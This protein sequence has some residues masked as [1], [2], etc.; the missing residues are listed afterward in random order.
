[1]G[2]A[3]QADEEGKYVKEEVLHNLI[4]RMRATSDDV[5]HKAS[6]LWVIDEGLAFH[7]YLA[8]DKPISSMPITGS[9][10]GLEPDLLALK[11]NDGP[12]LVS[13]RDNVSLASIVVVE[14]KRPMRKDAASGEKDPLNQALKYLERVREGKVTT[15]KGRLIPGSYQIPGFCYVISDLTSAVQERCKMYGLRRTQDN[16][17]YF[18]YNDNYKAYIEVMSFDRLLSLAHQRNRAFF[19][20]LGLTVA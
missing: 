12:F 8:S 17:G 11:V 19:D 4:M 5:D 16:L 13:E 20:S 15:A 1:M 6:N 14:I 10:S 3:I 9:T 2:K 7:N 18:G